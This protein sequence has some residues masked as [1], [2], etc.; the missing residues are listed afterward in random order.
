[1]IAKRMVRAATL[2]ASLTL[3]NILPVSADGI[4]P[5][6]YWASEEPTPCYVRGDVG[7]AW[8]DQN[9]TAAQ[10]G[11]SGPVG[12]LDFDDSWFGEVGLG[13]ARAL[14]ASSGGSIKDAPVVVS[15]GALR[16]EVVAGFRGGRDFHG[17]PPNPPAPDDPVR[18]HLRT[19]TLM[20]NLLYDF[21]TFHGFTP[22]VGGGLGVAFHDLNNVSFANGPAVIVQGR[23]ETD[24]AWQVMLGVARDLGRGTM[25]DL[26][27]RYV[28]LGEAATADGPYSL[29]VR[30]I[31]AHELKVGIRIPVGS[32]L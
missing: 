7:Y 23:D 18:T 5:F 20:F 24:F 8:H 10:A 17:L 16:A 11:V 15:R 19:F 4:P 3:L 28:D 12:S 29:R 9:A 14:T 27:Y 1:M 2:V 32:P 26:G 6:T 30:D 13:C 21:P 25:L 31:T 22:Y